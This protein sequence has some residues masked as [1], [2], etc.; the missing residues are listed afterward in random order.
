M[1][2]NLSSAA[3]VIGTSMVKNMVCLNNW[4]FIYLVS[5]EMLTFSIVM[6]RSKQ[7]NLYSYNNKIACANKLSFKN[8][9]I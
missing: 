5:M 8:E 3:V 1:S 4:H 7:I 9:F 2:Q 6:L